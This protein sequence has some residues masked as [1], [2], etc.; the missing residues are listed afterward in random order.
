[1]P[2]SFYNKCHHFL[3]RLLLFV[4]VISQKSSSLKR[5]RESLSIKKEEVRGSSRRW[6]VF[7][8]RKERPRRRGLLLSFQKSFLFFALSRV[9]QKSPLSGK[10]L[11]RRS[12]LF[13]LFFSLLNNARRL[14]RR[15]GKRSHPSGH[16]GCRRSSRPE[17]ANR[18]SVQTKVRGVFESV[19]GVCG[20]HRRRRDWGETL[21]RAVFRLLVMCGPLRGWTDD[22][23]HE[24]K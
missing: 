9:F 13:F 1:M 24:L 5:E 10:K 16:R 20:T 8:E 14:K 15:H 19:R 22:E 18:R 11:T 17:D 23:T 4:G 21:H 6:F 2:L 12:F 7:F 3:I